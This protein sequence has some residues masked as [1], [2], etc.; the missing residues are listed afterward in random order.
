MEVFPM[1]VRLSLGGLA[2][3]VIGWFSA[4]VGTGSP[5]VSGNILS[6]PLVLAFLTGY[7]IDVFFSL[8]DRLSGSLI[9]PQRDKAS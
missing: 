6:L 4:S 9:E 8:L 5:A 3:I 7:G 2:G 1:I